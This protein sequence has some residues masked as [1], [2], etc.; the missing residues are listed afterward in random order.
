M[1]TH[2]TYLVGDVSFSFL[3]HEESLMYLHTI[4]CDQGIINIIHGVNIIMNMHDT[5]L[6]WGC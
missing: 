2:D 5:Y 6:V 1:N 4:P 3:L